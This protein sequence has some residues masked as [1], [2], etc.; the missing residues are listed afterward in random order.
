MNKVL[1]NNNVGIL[2]LLVLSM[3][4]SPVSVMASGA[5]DGSGGGHNEPL[6]MESSSIKDGEENI[7]LQPEIKLVFS[8]NVVNIK[9]KD[10]NSKSI[11]LVTSQ[12]DIVPVEV[13]MEDDQIR[14]DKRREVV[15]KPKK[16]LNTNTKYVLNIN[17][18]FKSKSEISLKEPLKISFTTIKKDETD[19]SFVDIKDHWARSHIESVANLNIMNGTRKGYFSPNKNITRAELSAILSRTLNL[20]ETTD[21][22]HYKDFDSKAWYASDMEKAIKAGI[23]KV[24]GGKVSP[25]AFVTREEMAIAFTNACKYKG[26]KLSTSSSILFKD[27]KSIHPNA[28][29]A[30]N[31]M[32]HLKVM[33]GREDSKFAPKDKITRAETATMLIRLYDILK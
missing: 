7:A 24:E 31:A 10:H 3:C 8:K 25:N 27:G 1:K 32:Y 17:T 5:G 23:L 15:I 4:L 18:S 22:N 30:V 9:V 29:D 33:Q 11:S 21:L 12:G 28:M 6:T 26:V 2:F 16:R 19:Q 20:T 14:P 13:I